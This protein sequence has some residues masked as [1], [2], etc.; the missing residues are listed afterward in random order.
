MQTPAIDGQDG[1]WNTVH[2]PPNRPMCL[3]FSNAYNALD[4]PENRIIFIWFSYVMTRQNNLTGCTVR[5]T[6]LHLENPD[7]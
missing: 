1:R 6:D 3:S 7:L 2:L 4:E 5:K